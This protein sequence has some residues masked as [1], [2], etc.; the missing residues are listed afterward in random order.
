MQVTGALKAVAVY[1]AAKGLLAL[2]LGTGLLSLLHLHRNVQALATELIEHYHLNPASRFPSLF[3][4]AAAKLNDRRLSILALLAGLYVV[5]RFIEAWG[6]WKARTWAEW[7]TALSGG[8]YIPF[9]IAELI[10]RPSWWSVTILILN[11][12]IVAFMGYCL[13]SKNATQPIHLHTH[14]PHQ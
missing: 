5:L 7:L 4:D 9:E 13:M 10:E 12:G 3:I 2:L 1:E 11:V 8:V 6:L 14:H